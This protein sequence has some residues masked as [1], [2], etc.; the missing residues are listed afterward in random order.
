MNLYRRID[1]EVKGWLSDKNGRW[2]ASLAS[3]VPEHQ[4]IVQVGVYHG[5]SCFYMAVEAKAT[6][7]GI[8]PWD[9]PGERKT[10]KGEPFTDPEHRLAAYRHRE[11]LGLEDGV[12]FIRGF[13]V[14]VAKGWGI[15]VG[16]LMIDGEHTHEA[17]L[18]DARAW[19]PHLAPGA[20]VAI[21]DVTPKF[22]G[23]EKTVEVLEQEWGLSQRRNRFA[24][25]RLS[26]PKVGLR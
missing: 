9:L 18:A 13:S 10:S 8:D 24:W 19:E 17:S 4:A 26:L 12:E 25:W 21:D 15:P 1:R 22:A 14:E 11:N 23:V 16:L 7:Y 3:E 2:L 20:V 6:V 5:R